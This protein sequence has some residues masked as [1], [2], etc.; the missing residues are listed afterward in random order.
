MSFILITFDS[1]EHSGGLRVRLDLHKLGQFSL[2]PGQ[3][4][5]STKYIKDL[6]PFIEILNKGLLQVV[7][8]EGSNPSG[9][10]LIASK[11]VDQIPLPVDADV[12]LHPSKKQALD[13]EIHSTDVISRP[14]EISVVSKLV[15]YII[16]RH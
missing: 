12:D 16:S 11:L 13:K 4:K 6:D 14:E 8:I 7:G 1:V 2:F 9:H 3:V 15:S 5:T 10:C